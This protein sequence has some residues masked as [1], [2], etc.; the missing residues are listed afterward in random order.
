MD[1]VS[2]TAGAGLVTRW[3]PAR[4]SSTTRSLLL[5][6][7][8]ELVLPTREPVW[9]A[10]LLYVMTG[11]GVAEPAARQAI[12]R[13]ADAGWLHGEK[14]GR[15]VRWCLGATGVQLIEDITRRVDSLSSAPQRWDRNCLVV[16][17]SVPEEKRSVRKRLYDGLG[18]AGFGNPAPGLWASPHVDRLAETRRLIDDLG[19]RD[20]TLAFVGTTAGIGITDLEIVR[21]AWSLDEVAERYAQALATFAG[22][23]PRPGDDVL[24]AY[25]SLVEQWRQFPYLDPQLPHDLLP[26]WIGRRA[27]R[28]FVDLR[29]SWSPMARQRW[30][31]VVR[32]TSPPALAGERVVG[33]PL[34]TRGCA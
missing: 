20:S 25:L 4:P 12:G 19:L 9:T 29:T 11:L 32:A 6:V 1:D 26:D 17:V 21:R 27:I 10:A 14:V 30:H 22:A 13:A 15:E 5:T 7:L 24:L 2:E 28:I 18:W 8:A 34:S 16:A 23:E 31:E 33:R 3:R